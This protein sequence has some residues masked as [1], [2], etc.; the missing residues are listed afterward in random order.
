MQSLKMTCSSHNKKTCD[1]C[2]TLSNETRKIRDPVREKTQDQ[3][4]MEHHIPNN[5]SAMQLEKEVLDAYGIV[6]M[7]TWKEGFI[8]LALSRRGENSRKWKENQSKCWRYNSKQLLEVQ[9]SSTCTTKRHNN[10]NSSPYAQMV[11]QAYGILLE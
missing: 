3:S 8:G 7:A 1:D 11:L 10:L 5:S 9:Q 6:P 4:A 2:V